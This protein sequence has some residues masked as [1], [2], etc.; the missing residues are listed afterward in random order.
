MRCLSDGN[1]LRLRKHGLHRKSLEIWRDGKALIPRICPWVGFK[2]PSYV[3]NG[4]THTWKGDVYIDTVSLLDT[5]M[6]YTI[7]KMHAHENDPDQMVCFD[8]N[9]P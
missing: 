3:Y 7:I 2:R 9:M 4:Y 6:R 5:N 8:S 1:E